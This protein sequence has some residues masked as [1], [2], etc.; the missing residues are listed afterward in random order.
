MEEF[1]PVFVHNLG[2]FGLVMGV[3]SEYSKM[4]FRTWF[5]LTI[6]A[7]GKFNSLWSV[8]KMFS[9][10]ICYSEKVFLYSCCEALMLAALLRSSHIKILPL[11]SKG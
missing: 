9:S 1:C 8:Q 5:Y 7:R 6:L 2:F 11:G 4:W 3:K 10:A